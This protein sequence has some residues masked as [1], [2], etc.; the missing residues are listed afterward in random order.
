M[1]KI[2]FSF[3]I[4]G[5][6]FLTGCLETTQEITLSDDGSGTFSS[7]NDMSA[8]L[9]LAKQMGAAQ[10]M[11][12]A[13]DQKIDSSFSLAAGV[14]SI[15]NLTA[16]EKELVKKGTANIVMNLKEE[17]FVTNIKFPFS[18]AAEIPACNKLSGKILAETMKSQLGGGMP[19]GGSD[20][21]PESSSIDDYYIYEFS[22]GEL[23][24]KLNKEKYAGAADDEYLKG[25]K[26]AG[27]MG[28]EMK[29]NYIINLPRPAKEAE[30]KGIKLS[31]DKKKVTISVTLDDF[32]DDP[33]LL[34]F[35]IKY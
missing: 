15:P 29:S 8:L 22:N 19:M 26:E 17:K 23:K 25:I 14:D 31:D 28:L 18:T 27:S 24:K 5:S 16:D 10:E 32:F 21:M 12:K 11:E 4:T 3:L 35:K 1:K 34:E 6:L 13:G 2:L 33:S 20:Q 9:G 30:G 7:T